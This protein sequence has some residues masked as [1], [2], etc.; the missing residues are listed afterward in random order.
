MLGMG[1]NEQTTLPL[2][3]HRTSRPE[4][5]ETSMLSSM[6]RPTVVVKDIYTTY[7]SD[8]SKVPTM[9]K[10]S[11]SPATSG[12]GLERGYSAII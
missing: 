12:S 8:V 11:D 7:P 3:I 4:P 2:V 5:S 1:S 10:P 9:T 6:S